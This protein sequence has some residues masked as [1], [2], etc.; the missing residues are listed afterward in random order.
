MNHIQFRNNFP[1]IHY[2]SRILFPLFSLRRCIY[3]SFLHRRENLVDTDYLSGQRLIYGLRY[4]RLSLSL[5]PS[6][7]FPLSIYW[8]LL[9]RHLRIHRPINVPANRQAFARPKLDISL[10]IILEELERIT[11]IYAPVK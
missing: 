10:E 3:E 7:S 6:F 2:C 4:N 11:H 9:T 5:S 1:T 8:Q